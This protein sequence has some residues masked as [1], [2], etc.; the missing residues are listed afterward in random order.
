[1]A[2]E[3]A[4]VP[5]TGTKTAAAQPTTVV[6]T[7]TPAAADTVLQDVKYTVNELKAASEKQFGYGPEVIAGAIY[8]KKETS[9]SVDEM[10]TLIEAFLKKPLKDGG[11]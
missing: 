1:M 3:T 6:K 7:E 5:A 11:K 10:K 8:G 2:E 9:Y 4:V